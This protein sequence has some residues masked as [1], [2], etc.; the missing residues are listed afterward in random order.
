MVKYENDK[1]FYNSLNKS[2][3]NLN[4]IKIILKNI[5]IYFKYKFN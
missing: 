5:Y 4:L 1:V 3:V 2:S